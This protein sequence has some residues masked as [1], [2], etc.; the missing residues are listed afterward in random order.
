MSARVIASSPFVSSD[1]LK[2]KEVSTRDRSNVSVSRSLDFPCSQSVSRLGNGQLIPVHNPPPS[3][4]YTAS[5][6]STQTHS[7]NP[8]HDHWQQ[9]QNK[10]DESPPVH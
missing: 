4:P 7:A 1:G 3:I 6:I 9:P 2:R 10:P 5:E 8:Q